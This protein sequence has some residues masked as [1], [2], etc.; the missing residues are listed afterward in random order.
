MFGKNR[1]RMKKG[2]SKRFG[3]SNETASALSISIAVRCLLFH[4]KTAPG[5]VLLTGRPAVEVQT[6]HSFCL[7]SPSRSNLRPNEAA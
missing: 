5:S 7:R 1:E 4:M 6:K 3:N 2:Q